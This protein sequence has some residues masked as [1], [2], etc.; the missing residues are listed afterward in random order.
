[1][2]AILAPTKKTT[3]GDRKIGWIR[4]TARK[5]LGNG[6]GLMDRLA[7]LPTTTLPLWTALRIGPGASRRKRRAD[8]H[9]RGAT[10]FGLRFPQNVPSQATKR[11]VVKPQRD[12]NITDVNFRADVNNTVQRT[13][14]TAA[15][16]SGRMLAR[17]LSPSRSHASR[18]PN[19]L[20]ADLLGCELPIEQR[21]G[22][23]A[24]ASLLVFEGPQQ[25]R[26]KRIRVRVRLDRGVFKVASAGQFHAV[27]GVGRR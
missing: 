8:L 22:R 16:W 14:L 18:Y 21:R 23:I 4:H 17:R 3:S 12:V 27:I 7:V 15:F 20:A 2:T 25:G 10:S 13:L 11:A 19:R 5:D 1:M 6:S 26:S 9:L 24:S